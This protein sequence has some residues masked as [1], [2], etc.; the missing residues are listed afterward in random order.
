[1]EAATMLGEHAAGTEKKFVE[2]M[3][4]RA[5]ELQL[6]SAKFYNAH[7]L[8]A[9]TRHVF[10]SKLQNQMNAKDL[11]TLA[12]YVVNKY[13]EIIDITH[14]ERISVSSVE[15]FEYSGSSTNRLIFQLDGVDG[16]KTGTTNRAGACFVGTMLAVPGDE[17]SR[18]IAVVLG[19]EDNM[20]RY[21]KTGILLQF[22]IESYQK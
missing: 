6:D 13:P 22:G 4:G 14:K 10:S 2:M 9:Y 18:V 1:N 15:G 3:N 16:L 21:W 12:C 19:A 5:R 17:N 11:Y 8:P 7:G 20:E